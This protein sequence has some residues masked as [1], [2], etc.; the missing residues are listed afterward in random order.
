MLTQEYTKPKN[1]IR[2]TIN[3]KKNWHKNAY[4]NESDI[5]R[6]NGRGTKNKL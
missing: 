4:G 1:A 5:K 2:D 6:L 3:Y